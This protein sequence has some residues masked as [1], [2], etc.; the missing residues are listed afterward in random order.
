MASVSTSVRQKYPA[1][2]DKRLIFQTISALIGLLIGN[3]CATITANLESFGIANLNDLRRV[4]RPWPTSANRLPCKT[5][6]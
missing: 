3:I 1:I 4:N 5:W 2:D 6:R